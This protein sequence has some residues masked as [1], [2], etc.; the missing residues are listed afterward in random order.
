MSHEEIRDAENVGIRRARF[1]GIE[2]PSI[3]REFGRLPGPPPVSEAP[4]PPDPNCRTPFTTAIADGKLDV[5]DVLQP[6]YD[7]ISQEYGLNVQPD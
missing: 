3:Q 7:K 1:I 4:V 6:I 2:S 5:G